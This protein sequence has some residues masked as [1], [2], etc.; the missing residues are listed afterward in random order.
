MGVNRREFLKIAGISTLFGLGGK[1]AIEVLAPGELEARTEA[2]P[3][4]EGKRWA[5][6]VD[7]HKMDDALMDKCI[8]A[9]HREHNVPDLGNPKEEIKWLWKED[10]HHSFPGQQGG[11]VQ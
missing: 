4:T 10:Y 3:L 9:C 2:L 8:E 11:L 6:V 1:A 7:A 5:M